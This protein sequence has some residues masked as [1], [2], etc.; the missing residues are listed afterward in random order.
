MA[1]KQ[2]HV[3]YLG[4]VHGVGFRFTAENIALGLDIVGWVKNLPNAQV[5]V[6]AEAEEKVLWEFLD[7][8]R[9]SLLKKY[10]T[11]EKISWAEAT[12]K[13]QDFHIRF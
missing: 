13:Y 10:I 9:N 12:G 5:E 4:R 3:F 11:D 2:V 6:V 7:K 8:V 1:K